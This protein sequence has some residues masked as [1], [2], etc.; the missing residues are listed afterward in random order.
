MIASKVLGSDSSYLCRLGALCAVLC[1]VAAVL[2]VV[3]VTME[4]TAGNVA[5]TVGAL[6]MAL[7]G[8]FFML[9]G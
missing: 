4:P 6:G 1:G 5:A 2:G 3:L 8:S 9:R 7:L